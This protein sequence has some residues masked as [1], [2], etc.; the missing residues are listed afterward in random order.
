MIAMA[1]N[2]EAQETSFDAFLAKMVETITPDE[3]SFGTKK[4]INELDTSL[5]AAFLPLQQM[6]HEGCP[7]SPFSWR[8]GSYMKTK[9][10][11]IVFLE[12]ICWDHK[13]KFDY[14]LV[15]QNLTDCVLATYDERGVLLDARSVAHDGY[16]Y[17]WG[18]QY[19]QKNNSYCF[20]Q[21]EL[22]DPRQLW[23]PY[24]TVYTYLMEQMCVSVDRRGNIRQIPV[25]KPWRLFTHHMPGGPDD[26]DV[27]DL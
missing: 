7:E 21:G 12:R 27:Q 10:G 2:G 15:E 16:G 3:T 24:A 8:G 6:Q 11:Y 22:E 1:L 17:T 25:G 5:Y 18:M 4:Q 9:K 14:Y 26:G 20:T 23:Q 19:D 13:D